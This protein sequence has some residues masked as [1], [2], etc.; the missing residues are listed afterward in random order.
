MTSKQTHLVFAIMLTLACS[1]TVHTAFQGVDRKA[2][3]EQSTSVSTKPSK[4]LSSSASRLI[5][6]TKMVVEESLIITK[7][8]LNAIIDTALE[9]L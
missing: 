8:S 2:T 5:F 4:G 9:I 7:E 3:S 6:H 1:L